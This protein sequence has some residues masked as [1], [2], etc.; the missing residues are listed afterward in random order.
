M[1]PDTEGCIEVPMAPGLGVDIEEDEC[2]RQAFQ[3]R[4][5]QARPLDDFVSSKFTYLDRVTD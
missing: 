2:A 4:S 5:S 3:F 1:V